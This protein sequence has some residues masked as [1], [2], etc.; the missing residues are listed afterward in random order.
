MGTFKEENPITYRIDKMR[1]DW[2]E[3][4]CDD[5]QLVRWLLEKDEV[6]M[7][8][9][10]SLLESSEH[11]QVPDLFMNF[12]VPFSTEDQYG[13]DLLNSWLEI[14]NNE[15]ARKEVE[16]ANVLPDWDDTPY[17]DAP[18]KNSE[19]TFLEA[20]SSFVKSVDPKMK[21]VLNVMPTAYVGEPGFT[22]WVLNCLEVLPEN[23]RLMV[24]DLDEDPIFHK[25]PMHFKTVTIFPRLNMA[26]ATKEI[27]RQGDAN[28]PAVGVNLCI[29]NISEAAENK[30]EDGINR[31]G[32]EGL[33]VAEK[34]GLK[35]ILATMYL[36]YGSAFYQL[37]KM[38]DAIRLFEDGEAEAIQGKAEDDIAVPAVLLQ[39]YNF[40]AAAFLYTKKWDKARE[41][42]LKASQEAQEQKNMAFYMEAQRQASLMSEKLHDD[43]KAYDL[44]V[45]T[46]ETCK[47]LDAL[48]VK[49]T[50]ML[51]ICE[52]LY[53]FAY[54]Q[55]N[56]QLVDEIEEYASNIWGKE[57]KDVSQ[58]EV[59]QNILTTE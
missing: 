59:Y 5:T 57:W 37:K 13:L 41:A 28:D 54:D 10:F 24:Y 53:E 14:W 30:D 45:E 2:M 31:W 20:M 32:K 44:L 11:G 7:V 49:F 52:R 40:Q 23:L 36:A 9:A 46:Y 1:K 15:D 51:L 58:K 56:K 18:V 47:P 12:D 4:V 42:F 3:N 17:K 8:K 33:E 43:E 27:V 34:T 29:L 55:K 48:N 16:P 50:S 35:S 22:D 25:V 38:K 21:L 6:R 19:R 26:E 39:T